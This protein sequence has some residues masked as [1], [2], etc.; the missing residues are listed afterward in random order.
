MR[1][2]LILLTTIGIGAT[3]MRIANLPPYSP[4]SDVGK[5][6]VISAAGDLAWSY[7]D[8]ASGGVVG[9]TASTNNDLAAWSGTGG[10][11]LI[12]SGILLSN[13]AFGA[14]ASS[15]VAN[16]LMAYAGTGGRQTFDSGIPLA[17]VV[18]VSRA[19]QAGTGLTVTNSGLLSADITFSI[20]PNKLQLAM[21]PTGTS[22][23][24]ILG[25]TGATGT[26][27]SAISG[28]SGQVCRVAGSTLG[29][30]AISL[31]DTTN[32]VGGV[33]PI[34]AGGTSASTAASGFAN[35]SPLTSKGDLIGYSTAPVRIPT[36]ATGSVLQSDP[37]AA[38]GVSY[39]PVSY[40]EWSTRTA[41]QNVANATWTAVQWNTAD[42]A[43]VSSNLTLASNGAGPT[44]TRITAT[45]AGIYQIT[46]NIT[47]P[48]ASTGLRYVAVDKNTNG[49]HVDASTIE[50]VSFAAPSGDIF[51]VPFATQ[52]KLAAS[53]Y[54]EV[55]CFQN[56][57]ASL[58][59]PTGA[60]IDSRV[61]VRQAAKQ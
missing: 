26:N 40:A 44:G 18:L 38:A 48:Q 2:I 10:D 39:F 56:S 59:L 31:S 53:D 36:G 16:D 28:T 17:N 52:V 19:V 6:P 23:T 14:T 15:V 60:P 42:L 49:T 7:P 12:D 20:S 24:A 57:G 58:A 33:L 35:L 25:I 4:T 11:H 32:T 55:H 46:G 30:G 13:V 3:A 51:G 37:S 1:N 5:V 9:P 54:I 21:L 47:F 61:Q 45:A 8:A 50:R 22:A 34:G 43:D 29:F 41:S 27:Y